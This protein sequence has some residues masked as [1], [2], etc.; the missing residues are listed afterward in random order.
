MTFRLCYSNTTPTLALGSLIST[1][2]DTPGSGIVN[3]SVQ[4]TAPASEVWVTYTGTTQPFYNEWASLNLARTGTTNTWTGTLSLGTQA[5]ADVRYVVQAFG[6]ACLYSLDTNHGRYYTPGVT[7][8]TP[9]RPEPTMIS[10]VN[11]PTTGTYGEML[12]VTVELKKTDGT[13]L[14]LQRVTVSLGSQEQRVTTAANGQATARLGLNDP[15]G[16]Y[17]LRAT[18]NG[19]DTLLPASAVA[20]APFALAK[21]TTALTVSTS[22]SPLSGTLSAPS[23]MRL[24]ATL[25][26]SSGR[27]IDE[28]T[29]IFVVAGPNGTDATSAI[30]NIGGEA[31]LFF[32]DIALPAGDYTIRAYFL[33]PISGPIDLGNGKTVTLT[34]DVYLP[35]SA[36][37]AL[38]LRETILF[39]STRNNNT[40]IYVMNANGSGEIALTT[41]AKIDADP[42]WSSTGKIVF[43]STRTGNGDIYVMNADGSEQTRLTTD[44][45]VDALGGWSPDGT[46]IVFTS[47]RNNNTD[48]YVMNANGSAQ[49]RLTTNQALDADPQWSPDGTKI[50]FTSTR[51]GNTNIYV[52]NTD[53][54]GQ[55]RLTNG[56][57]IDT[58]AAWSPSGTKIAFTSSRTGNGDIYVMNADG[59]GQTRLTTDP[60]IDAAPDWS[61][62]G[63]KIIFTSTRT[64]SGDI[65]IMN[66]DGTSQTRLTINT[67]FDT[68]P[69]W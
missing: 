11:A 44:P 20:P 42:N 53:G 26:G 52:M 31:E 33:S 60:G 6:P 48:I 32:R 55:T 38:T 29:I 61:P 14:A 8:G 3:F 65:Y 45:A 51:N 49:T 1:V 69:N 18:F 46:K 54:T 47:S 28:Q 16:T 58:L 19:S 7:T 64:G 36:S 56:S 41:D 21:Q 13:P 66:A 68:L 23:A 10:L 5:A 40:D 15:A 12:N 30:T 17:E 25:R 22:P 63:T 67:V 50:I 4:V 39:T 2:S 37:A 62:D 59:S 24:V 27:P 57:G 9:A 43:T 34:S 35:A